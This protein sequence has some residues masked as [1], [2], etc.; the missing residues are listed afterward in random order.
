MGYKQSP[1]SC[2]QSLRKETDVGNF[3]SIP[4]DSLW[5]PDRH[6][7]SKVSCQVCKA[8][9]QSQD[10]AQSP[11]CCRCHPGLY[12]LPE[13]TAPVWGHCVSQK[14]AQPAQLIHLSWASGAPAPVK[15][16][17]GCSWQP[18]VLLRAIL[19]S[20]LPL[21]VQKL[22]TEAQLALIAV[23]NIPRVE[24]SVCGPEFSACS[25]QPLLLLGQ[26]CWAFWLCWAVPD[27]RNMVQALQSSSNDA[28]NSRYSISQSSAYGNRQTG[29]S[30]SIATKGE[31]A[32]A[33][34]LYSSFRGSGLYAK[35][36][37]KCSSPLCWKKASMFLKA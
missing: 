24:L 11:R 1:T 15:P 17:G 16:S 5:T 6:S 19:S 12:L 32:V 30:L 26:L 14:A 31:V 35:L 2:L 20:S 23:L 13:Q 27:E 25:R 8:S 10:L 7:E 3:T 29:R 36:P 34:I 18:L 28:N 37:S 21:H 33:V 22:V 9:V 4:S